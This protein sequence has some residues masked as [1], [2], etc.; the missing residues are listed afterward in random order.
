MLKGS[1]V[2]DQVP[3]EAGQMGRVAM[4][5]RA[6][7]STC[8]CSMHVDA[9]AACWILACRGQHPGA[10]FRGNIEGQHSRAT[11]RGNIQ[12]QLSGATIR[13]NIQGQLSGATLPSLIVFNVAW[14]SML[15]G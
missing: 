6:A 5:G 14:L 10:T 15:H 7:V 13:G 12:G 9:L 8:C 4:T 2:G 1:T 11:F 3:F